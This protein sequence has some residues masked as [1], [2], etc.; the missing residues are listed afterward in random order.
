LTGHAIRE[1]GD[2]DCELLVELIRGGFRDVAERFGLT[3]ENCPKH[4]SNCTLDWI[5]RDLE[6]GVIYYILDERDSP[7]GLVGLEQANEKVYYVERLT[8][9]PGSRRRGLGRALLDH[10]IRMA[11]ESGAG[12]VEIAIISDDTALRDWYA[13]SGFAV[14]G[15]RRFPHLPFEVTFMAMDHHADDN[16][17]PGTKATT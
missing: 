4:P 6:R 11:A 15:R 8:V 14:T 17:D 1:A 10:A 3:E 13:G 16:P 7:V 12:R 2:E 5:R 9:L